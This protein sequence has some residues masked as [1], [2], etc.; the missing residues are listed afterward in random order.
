MAGKSQAPMISISGAVRLVMVELR[1]YRGLRY[2]TAYIPGS[3][4]EMPITRL[5]PA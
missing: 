5:Q 1:F 3:F 2:F 4:Q